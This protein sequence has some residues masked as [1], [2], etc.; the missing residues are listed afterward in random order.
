MHTR[1]ETTNSLANTPLIAAQ[2]PLDS[3][4]VIHCAFLL[5][6][7]IAIPPSFSSFLFSFCCF[8]RGVDGALSSGPGDGGNVNSGSGGRLRERRACRGCGAVVE[9]E[10]DAEAMGMLGGRDVGGGSRLVLTYVVLF[11]ACGGG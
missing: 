9:L 7:E 10:D 11:L 6:S 8:T 5:K 3:A 4:N 2:A 1:R